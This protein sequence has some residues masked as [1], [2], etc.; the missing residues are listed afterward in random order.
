[1]DC[2]PPLQEMEVFVTSWDGV[3]YVS[4]ITREELRD[5]RRIEAT[6]LIDISDDRIEVDGSVVFQG[7]GPFVRDMKYR[8]E[9]Q[10]PDG[11]VPDIHGD[12]LCYDPETRTIVS[13]Y[14][15]RVPGDRPIEV[16]ISWSVDLFHLADINRDGWVDGA[17]MGLLY[18][19]WGLEGGRSD[20]NSD[21][22][23]DGRDLGVLLVQW[24]G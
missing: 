1:M 24:D 19:D 13:L 15:A 12:P 14:T 21:G 3:R 9:I 11:M 17:D 5:R 8:G 16:S 7:V 23:V 10:V 22:I 20:L 18:G 4:A 2:T 6:Y